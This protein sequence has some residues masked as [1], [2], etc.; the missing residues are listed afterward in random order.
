M[1]VRLIDSVDE[2]L[3]TTEAYRSREPYLTN[4]IGSVASSIASGARHYERCWWWVAEHDGEV[5]G[6]MMRT[7]PFKLILSPL[8][9]SDAADAAA[10][11]AR[12]DAGLDGVTGPE[13][14][15]A[16]FCAALGRA[17][18]IERGTLAYAI[19]DLVEPPRVAGAPRPATLDDFD[20]LLSWRYAMVDEIALEAF[21]HEAA[22]RSA[23]D[24]GRTCLWEV[25]GRPVC[26]V[27]CAL[28]VATPAGRVSRVGP[29]YTPLAQRRR[30]FAASLTGEVTRRLLERGD[31]VMLYTDAANATSNGVYTRLG[32]HLIARS[33]EVALDPA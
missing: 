3:A 26:M 15:V 10:A 24:D 19:D 8:S 2:F 32:Y 30:G 4:V 5:V 9:P 29:V 23:I 18:T 13:D 33:V 14:V 1:S 25:E 17:A 28:P 6:V 27:G 21:D 22:L 31:R 12:V 11:V 20:T 16:G 7:E